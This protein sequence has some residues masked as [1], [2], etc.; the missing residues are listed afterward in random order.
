MKLDKWNSKD[1][2]NSKYTLEYIQYM[3]HITSKPI[4]VSV[5]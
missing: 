5:R 3:Q 4:V 1:L 2:L